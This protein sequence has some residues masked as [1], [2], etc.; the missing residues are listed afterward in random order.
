MFLNLRKQ[1]IKQLLHSSL[2]NIDRL[3]AEL[4]ISHVI[5]KP[6]EFLIARPEYKVGKFK[7]SKVKKLIKK[8]EQGIPL[9][10]LTGHKEF[11]GLDFEVNKHTLIPRP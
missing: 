11:F 10:Y 6:R 9:A 1:T 8:R 3:D 5:D 7:S 2:N 4:L